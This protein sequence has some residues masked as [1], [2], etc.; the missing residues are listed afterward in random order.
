MGAILMDSNTG[1]IYLDE[2]NNT[3]QVDNERGFQQIIDGLFQCEVGSEPMNPFYGFDL[4][5]AIRESSFANS[6][7]YIEAL[8]TQALDPQVEKLISKVEYVE[9]TQSGREMNV[10]IEVS[11][12]LN[13]NVRVELDL[14]E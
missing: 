9:A 6:E 11:S 13:D 8:I 14:G 2:Y 10:T 3:V 4:K 7:M 12:V 5:S 1:D